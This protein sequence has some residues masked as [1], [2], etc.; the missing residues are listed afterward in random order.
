MKR[1]TKIEGGGTAKAGLRVAAYARVST[2]EEDQQSSIRVQR[3]HYESYIKNNP[4]WEFAGVYYDEGITGTKKE[5]RPGLMQMMEDCRNGRIDYVITKSVS[6]FARNSADCLELTRTLLGIGIPIYFEKENIDTSKMEGELL[7]SIMGGIAQAESASISE[8]NKLGAK[9][10]FQNGTFK[11]SCPPYGYIWDKD[12]G[13][14]LINREEA[15]VVRYI[16]DET[17]AGRGRDSIAAELRWRGVP[18]RKGGA[19]SASTVGDILKNEKYMGDCLFQKTYTD[20]SFRKHRNRGEEDQYYMEGHHEPIISRETFEAASRITEQHRAEKG[21]QKESGKYQKRYPMTGKIE[22]GTCGGRM[23]RRIRS[24]NKEVIYSCMTHIHDP[25][26]CSMKSIWNYRVEAAFVRMMNKLIF[27][28]EQL[29]KPFCRALEEADSA[30]VSDEMREIDQRIEKLAEKKQKFRIL[31]TKELIG[32]S[33]YAVEMAAAASEEGRL[34]RKK[35]QLSEAR[36]PAA[37]GIRSAKELCRYA[38]KGEMLMEFDAE[39]FERFVEK[40]VVRS[41]D[42]LVFVLKCGLRLAER[43]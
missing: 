28:K 10:R 8:N 3:E 12:S 43:M 30:D 15:E 18:A 31:F 7:L 36:G 11:I 40:I 29:L 4:G 39:A 13:R 22:C 38:G 2:D 33:V 6:R 21:I 1:I 24:D 5:K 23:R 20:Q 19:W 16:F 32:P 14:L 37:D 25:R 34:V 17:I 42:E 26:S 35:E 41:R 9:Y 27:S